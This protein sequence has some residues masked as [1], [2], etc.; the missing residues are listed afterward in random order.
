MHDESIERTPAIRERYKQFVNA[1]RP[2]F[3]G[4]LAGVLIGL[5]CCLLVITLRSGLRMIRM[6]LKGDASGIERDIA[7]ADRAVAVLGMVVDGDE[8][9]FNNDNPAFQAY[10]ARF[11]LPADGSSEGTNQLAG[12]AMLLHEPPD[13]LDEATRLRLRALVASEIKKD[14]DRRELPLE[15]TGGRRFLLVDLELPTAYLHE[16]R[17]HAEVPL[18]PF[19]MEP[20]D[21]GRIVPL[22]YWIAFNKPAPEW[23]HWAAA[24]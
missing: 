19:L 13:T 7:F 10:P 8:R 16:K 20:V 21:G 5:L 14:G 22:P 18:Q 17:L 9:L 24:V 2:S 23:A 3:F 15:A 6:S 12:V 4:R 1:R 11:L